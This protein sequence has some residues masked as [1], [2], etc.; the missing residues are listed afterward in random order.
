MF[1]STSAYYTEF[2]LSQSNCIWLVKEID[3]QQANQNLIF[4]VTHASSTISSMDI[5]RE[6]HWL[7]VNYRISYKLSLLTWKALHTAEP[8]YLSELIFHYAPTR[9][10]RSANTGLLALL[11]G[12][13]IVTFLH[14]PFLFLLH[15][16]VILYLHTFAL[17]TISA[18]LSV[19]LNRTFSSQL[20]LPSHSVPATPIR[21]SRFWRSIYLVVCMHVCMWDKIAATLRTNPKLYILVLLSTRTMTASWI[22]SFSVAIRGKDDQRN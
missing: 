19:I 16:S 5:C 11:T 22:A 1:K 7:P 4:T 20:S 2:C 17:S 15:Q 9:T 3:T 13:T 18:H 10:L 8:S 6:L 12:I 14:V 21:S